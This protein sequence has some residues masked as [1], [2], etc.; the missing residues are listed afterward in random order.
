M[1]GKEEWIQG[2]LSVAAEFADKNFQERVW[3]RGEGPEISSWEEAMCRFFDDYDVDS[4]LEKYAK[5]LNLTTTQHSQLSALRDELN[6]FG[7][8]VGDSPTAE[9]VLNDPNWTKIRSLASAVH[10]AFKK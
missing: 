10:D 8:R 6:K 5:E 4:L 2:L 3:L 9:D 1:M 7:K